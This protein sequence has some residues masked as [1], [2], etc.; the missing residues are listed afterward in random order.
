[1][2]DGTTV[3]AADHARLGTNFF[4]AYNRGGEP[5]FNP[6]A[7]SSADQTGQSAPA[8]TEILS[9][10][11]SGDDSSNGGAASSSTTGESIDATTQG[12][13]TSAESPGTGGFDTNT[14]GNQPTDTASAATTSASPQTT[15]TQGGTP[16]AGEPQSSADP[17]G[18]GNE[19]DTGGWFPNIPDVPTGFFVVDGEQYFI[20]TDKDG[21]EQMLF[22][23]DGTTFTASAVKLT[24][25][26]KVIIIPHRIEADLSVEVTPGF[27]ITFQPR[28]PPPPPPK[29]D[30]FKEIGKAFKSVFDIAGTVV[31]HV[32][33][34]GGKLFEM[35]MNTALKTALDAA[36]AAGDGAIEMSELTTNGQALLDIT[37]TA[38]DSAADLMKRGDDA[39]NELSKA[40]G[41]LG[42]VEGIL[43][44]IKHGSGHA[45]VN[46]L[47]SIRLTLKY[48]L[49]GRNK[50][51]ALALRTITQNWKPLT[52]VGT[53]GGIAA[54]LLEIEKWSV[55][56]IDDEGNIDQERP[57]WK[58]DD[59]KRERHYHVWFWPTDNLVA[60]EATIMALDGGIGLRSNTEYVKG[61]RYTP[62][63][64]TKLSK[65]T[66]ELLMYTPAVH[67]TMPQR[68]FGEVNDPLPGLRVADMPRENR[69]AGG[70]LNDMFGGQPAGNL[71][72]RDPDMVTGYRVR[73]YLRMLSSPS[74]PWPAE[75]KYTFDRTGVGRDTWIV[76]IDTGFELEIDELASHSSD[77]REIRTYV[78][79]NE[80]GAKRLE[81]ID[82]E[83]VAKGWHHA[84]EDLTDWGSYDEETGEWFGHGT[85]VAAVAG[86]RY[87]GVSPAAN[88]YLIKLGNPILDGIHNLPSKFE[89]YEHSGG[90]Q[91]LAHVRELLEKGD[92][93]PNKTILNLSMSTIEYRA[94]ESWGEKR[95][96]EFYDGWKE[97]MTILDKYN[98]T[99]VVCAGNDGLSPRA[100]LANSIP[101]NFITPDTMHMNVGAVNDLGQMSRMTTKPTLENEITVW[102]QGIQVIV[103]DRNNE[104][105]AVDGTSY[106][107]PIVAALGA[108]FLS[109]PP[110]S[111]LIGPG[112][113]T[114]KDMILKAAYQRCPRSDF[115]VPWL[116]MW[117]D[118][119]EDI[120]PKRIPVAYN[121]AHGPQQDYD[122]TD[123]K[124]QDNQSGLLR[125]QTN[126][127]LH[128]VDNYLVFFHIDI[129]IDNNVDVHIHIHIHSDADNISHGSDTGTA[130]PVSLRCARVLP[131]WLRISTHAA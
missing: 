130:A 44:V 40:V 60:F 121:L 55:A 18:D 54:T 53:A 71:S 123:A 14:G 67:I 97:M 30:L 114:V 34:L 100:N 126:G 122:C 48:G 85:S 7:F 95:Y 101:N 75:D 51:L 59:S 46:L 76:I 72:K 58:D 50:A 119:D 94:I 90:I 84:P 52:G 12:V 117:G 32:G 35:A 16:G 106:S 112:K 8:P 108:Y 41:S 92:L 64:L 82:P 1:M 62:C 77:Y 66:A 61:A 6:L 9:T 19:D 3:V 43:S 56:K 37:E 74:K 4:Y 131:I 116:D 25:D 70:V 78:V 118:W 10:S 22:R 102:A 57:K 120:I 86:G 68:I 39:L 113:L 23:Q 124:Q 38:L 81:D 73:N 79:P 103:M 80:K 11:V 69:R 89:N 63:Y 28:P 110:M 5:D 107:A 29:F 99:L 15:S 13:E 24:F 98:V 127:E 104:N 83:L 45:I 65:A 2:P 109:T 111:D 47:R 17:N 115:Q 33:D 88:L 96:K 128:G 36:A 105:A 125:R 26:N 27:N 31:K 42:K 21:S 129:D 20:P 91:A 87:T 93:P 49:S